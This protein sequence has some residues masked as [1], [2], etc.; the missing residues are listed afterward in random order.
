MQ[1]V[2]TSLRIIQERSEDKR[3]GDFEHLSREL[4]VIHHAHM[5]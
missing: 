2:V 3:G 4:Q 1:R 5:D